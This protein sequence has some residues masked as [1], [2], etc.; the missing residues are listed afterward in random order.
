MHTGCTQPPHRKAARL[1]AGARR[2]AKVSEQRERG[3][4][5]TLQRVHIQSP[6]SNC[7]N[8]TRDVTHLKRVRLVQLNAV[9]RGEMANKAGGEI[10]SVSSSCSGS[11]HERSRRGV[12][13]RHL[14]QTRRERAW[15]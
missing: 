3:Q 2:A 8:D 6:R 12:L 5:S 15:C 14:D 13:W 11:G 7:G 4:V 1:Q 10:A 9:G